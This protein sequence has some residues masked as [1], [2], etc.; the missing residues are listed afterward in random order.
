MAGEVQQ[1]RLKEWQDRHKA[2]PYKTDDSRSLVVAM[3]GALQQ[4]RLK[5]WQDR[6]KAYPYK[7]EK[8]ATGKRKPQIYWRKT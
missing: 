7:T 8:Q 4:D 6:H 1:D 5:E 3:A 2:Y